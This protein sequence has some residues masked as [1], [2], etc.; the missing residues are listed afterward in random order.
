MVKSVVIDSGLGLADFNITLLDALKMA[1]A[2]WDTVTPVTVANCFLK[3]GFISQSESTSELEEVEEDREDVSLVTL[4]LHEPCSFEEYASINDSICSAPLLTSADIVTLVRQ[5]NDTL[6]DGEDDDD[7]C[8]SL[9]KVTNHW[10]YAA[11]QDIQAYLL[12]S[13]SDADRSY[14]I[15]RDLEIELTKVT[16]KTCKQ[17]LIANF[18]SNVYYHNY[19]YTCTAVLSYIFNWNF[20]KITQL[21]CF[22]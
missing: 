13:A 1:R 22:E 12:C 21:F 3:G 7:T 14:R 4:C 8:D 9:P 19:V 17:C 15:L 11:F 10:A 16:S 5:N 18:C 6:T 2:T 20:W